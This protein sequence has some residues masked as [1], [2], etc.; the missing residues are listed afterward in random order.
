MKERYQKLLESGM[1][2]EFYPQL[3][4][5]WQL[6]CEEFIKNETW[7]DKNIRKHNNNNEEINGNKSKDSK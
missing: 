1:F 6:D 4:G 5:I 3:S 7:L 2:W